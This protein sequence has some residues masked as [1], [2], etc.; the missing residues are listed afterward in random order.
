VLDNE[1]SVA[2]AFEETL[3]EVIDESACVSA[4][5]QLVISAKFHQHG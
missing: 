5:D 3:F 1:A 4:R 2:T